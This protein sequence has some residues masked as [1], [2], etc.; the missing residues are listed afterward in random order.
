MPRDSPML[1]SINDFD[2]II[3]YSDRTAFTTPDPSKGAELDSAKAAGYSEGTYHLTNIS[4]QSYSVNFTGTSVAIYGSSGP[5]FGSYKVNLDGKETELS[6]WGAS[7]TNSEQLWQS[8]NLTAGPVHSL[9]VTNGNA[10]MLLDY[11]DVMV[12]IAA[13]GTDVHTTVLDEDA[14][15]WSYTGEW[16]HNSNFLFSGGK[17]TYTNE[18]GATATFTFEGSTVLLFGDT[19][20]NH[21]LYSVQLDDRLPETF[22]SATGCGLDYQTQGLCELTTPNMMYYASYLKEGKHVMKI[23]NVAGPNKTF[24]DIDRAVYLRPQQYFTAP[25]IPPSDSPTGSDS[26]PSTTSD[27]SSRP[28]GAAA[29]LEFPLASAV[30]F[31]ML[32]LRYIF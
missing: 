24:I 5:E 15:S 6:A 26:Q 28:T 17:S 27:P 2:S 20:A 22:M 13:P 23:T 16:G 31:T 1:L 14:W 18:D 10:S 30:F 7:T 8:A 4:G 9:T 32:V 29:H 25:P 19:N 11:L 3:Q 12:D 21:G